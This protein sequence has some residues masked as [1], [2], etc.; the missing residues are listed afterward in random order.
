MVG[1][2]ELQLLDLELPP[3]SQICIVVED[4]KRASRYYQEKFGIGPF[5]FPEIRYNRITYHGENS[6]GYWEM[7]FARWGGWELELA[8]PVKPPSIYQDFLDEK[9]EGFHH[10]GF[11]IKNIDEYIS[12]AEKL[13]ITVL[14]SGRTSSGGFAHLDTRAIGGAIFEIIERKSMRV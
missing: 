1:K 5:V 13:S 10:L 7:A 4:L 2:E 14:M 3:P 6:A 9:G 8:M 11:D 12:K